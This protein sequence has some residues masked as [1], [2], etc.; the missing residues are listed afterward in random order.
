MTS[1]MTPSA[2]PRTSRRRD[3]DARAT[4]SARAQEGSRARGRLPSAP[5]ERR[6][7]LAALAVILIVGGALLAGLLAAR[8][9]QR[10]E[11]LVVT[12]TIE[13][14]R[15]IKLEDLASTPAAAS[16]N[17]LI[18]A[19]RADEIVGQI[20]RVELTKGEFVQTTQITDSSPTADGHTIVG[21]SLEAGRFPAGG[22]SPGDVVDIVS[23]VNGSGSSG[24][25]AANPGPGSG[26][27]SGS[28]SGS[29]TA[30]LERS[31]SGSGAD[32]GTASGSV[33]NAQVLDAVPSS[34]KDGDWTS[35]ATVS[36]IVPTSQAAGTA[37][38]GAS[39]NAAVVVTATG[40][41]IGEH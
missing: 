4:S 5:R 20:A 11:M 6:P 14:G 35:G 22:L 17:T 39:N 27:G 2:D 26:G 34:G 16:S 8:V 32:S 21:L 13:A 19:S 15:A 38:L 12:T 18:P 23:V 29:G 1:E 9:D 25:S 33:T 24:A 41:P 10:E 30:P 31:D 28:S 37:A 3:R 7:L 36:V 40:Q